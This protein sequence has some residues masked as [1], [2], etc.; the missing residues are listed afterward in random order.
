MLHR[1]R[2]TQPGHA[3]GQ[4]SRHPGDPQPI[5]PYPSGSGPL[6]PKSI[7]PD[8]FQYKLP[9]EPTA[10]AGLSLDLDSAGDDGAMAAP[11]DD[12]ATEIA[13]VAGLEDDLD[14]LA[15]L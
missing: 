12:F 10:P 1:R 11:V 2:R 9:S 15:D 6:E 8:D 13:E 4:P 7:G 14:G 5:D 3:V